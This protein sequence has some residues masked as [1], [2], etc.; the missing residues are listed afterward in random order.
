MSSY[1]LV[2][3]KPYHLLVELEYKIYW[4]VKAFNLNL[5]DDSQHRK[6]QINELEELRNDAN[7]NSKTHKKRIAMFYDKKILRKTI[8][9]DKNILL[10]NSRLHLFSGKL[11]SRWSSLFIMKHVY[12]YGAFNIK[13]NNVFIVN[14][15]RLKAYFDN[16]PSENEFIGFNEF[17][18]ID[19]FSHIV[20]MS[21]FRVT[22]VLLVFFQPYSNGE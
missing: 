3:E 1:R 16:F 19:Y 13:N 12:S 18:K 7:R 15:H 5:D 17:I 14:E 4:V 8:D 22:F 10:Y 6:L 2:Y 9:V 11:R 21:P 20:F